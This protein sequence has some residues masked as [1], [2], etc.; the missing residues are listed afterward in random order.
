MLTSEVFKE[1]VWW[2]ENCFS[3][4]A[5]KIDSH[6]K[7]EI[8]VQTYRRKII[9]SQQY[10]TRTWALKTNKSR[11]ISSAAIFLWDRFFPKLPLSL[12]PETRSRKIRFYLKSNHR[13]CIIVCVSLRYYSRFSLC[14]GF[15]YNRLCFIFLNSFAD[16]VAQQSSVWADGFIVDFVLECQSIWKFFWFFIL[17]CLN[18]DKDGE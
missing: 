4:K 11:K 3:F 2:F 7:P 5:C 6:R 13:A 15:S 10:L 16:T 14:F 1:T 17:D 12:P 18:K 8:S 9:S